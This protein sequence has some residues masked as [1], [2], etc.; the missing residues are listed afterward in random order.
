MSA[1]AATG[2]STD[3]SAIASLLNS[4]L[5]SQATDTPQ[6]GQGSD[7]ASS[8]SPT[9]SLD[10]SDHAKAVLA[11]AQQGQVAADKL[12]DLLQSLR[13]PS[14]KSAPSSN[15]SSTNISFAQLSGQQASSQS[16][17]TQWQAGSIYGDPTISDAAFI[18]K[19]R[20][21]MVNALSGLPSDKVASLE[22]AISNGTVK[23]QPASE[24][25]GYNNRTTITYTGPPGGLQGMSSSAYIPPTGAVKDAIDQGNA[26]ALW[27]EDRGDVY[28]TW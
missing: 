11:Q 10:L 20:G 27:T 25:P 18:D 15:Q 12:S 3:Y 4:G 24:V 1:I 19:Y 23:I 5:S 22:A 2:S 28:I 21:A 9:D 17:S 8:P 14:G 6:A 26:I 7:P 16:N 13:D